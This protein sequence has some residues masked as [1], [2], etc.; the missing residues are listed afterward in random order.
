LPNSSLEAHGLLV[1]GFPDTG[2]IFGRQADVA[3]PSPGSFGSHGHRIDFCESAVHTMLLFVCVCVSLSLSLYILQNPN[4][5]IFIETIYCE[6]D[7][8]FSPMDTNNFFHSWLCQSVPE[9]YL[10][11]HVLLSKLHF[12]CR[13]RHFFSKKNLPPPKNDL[14]T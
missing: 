7:W 3:H 11:L 9:D 6:C 10:D 8:Q 5:I 1:T 13:K 12:L 4:I 2:R 14:Q